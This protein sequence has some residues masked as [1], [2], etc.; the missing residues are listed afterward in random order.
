MSW[1][2]FVSG[3][4]A[5]QLNFGLTFDPKDRGRSIAKKKHTDLFRFYRKKD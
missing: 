1:N 3:I 4:P 5:E 2:T